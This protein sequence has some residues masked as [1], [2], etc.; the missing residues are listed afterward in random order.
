MPSLIKA[1]KMQCWD[2]LKCVL[3]TFI[4][5]FAPVACP[6]REWWMEVFK[7]Q[8]LLQK[9]DRSF[10]N[11]QNLLWRVWISGVLISVKDKS[12]YFNNV[13]FKRLLNHKQ[14]FYN[15]I[16]GTLFIVK[17]EIFSPFFKGF[18]DLTFAQGI[19]CIL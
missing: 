3:D 4:F 15:D 16:P 13:E 2:L 12:P 10:I 5:L 11:L 8:I 17:W 18:V 7:K 9:E 14:I 19:D 1:C 6:C